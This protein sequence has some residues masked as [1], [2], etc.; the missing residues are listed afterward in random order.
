M[1]PN[2]SFINRYGNEGTFT[3][4]A[5]QV[6]V[7]WTPNLRYATIYD[8]KELAEKCGLEVLEYVALAE[9]KPVSF[10]PNLRG[11]LAVFRL[12]K[13]DLVSKV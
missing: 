13:R 11:S 4:R 12:R 5:L 6:Q 9:G 3:Y 1:N 8:F 10:L 7:A 2:Y